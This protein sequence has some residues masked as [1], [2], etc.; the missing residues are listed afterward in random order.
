LQSINEELQS[1]NEELETSKEEMQSLNEELTTVNA[2]LQSK[3]DELSRTND[4]MQNLL[5]STDI[6]TVF[7]D[8]NLNIKRFTD[9]AREL[10]TLRPT[11]VGRPISDLTSNVQY[12]RLASDCREVLQTLAFKQ[13]EVHTTD[14]KWYLMR[15]MPYRTAE[16]IID[17]IVLTFVNIGQLKEVE[18]GASAYFSAIVDTVREPLIVLDPQL[19]VV[20]ANLSFYDAFHTTP[21]QTESELIYELGAGQWDIPK[22][23]TLLEDIL[24]K[25]S[26]FQDYEVEVKLPKEGR[27]LFSLNARRMEHPDS[28]KGL[29]LL[30]MKDVTIK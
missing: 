17:G 10:V 21:K 23:R 14:D 8:N 18:K 29:I 2:E 13:I 4:D 9:K 12:D 6:A 20:S 3:V 1:T 7:L 19:R 28:I 27:R 24:P 30:S 16:N 26:Q 5:N 25:N 15:I 11:D 22:L